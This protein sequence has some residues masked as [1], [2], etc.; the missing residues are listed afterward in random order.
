MPQPPSVIVVPPPS[1]YPAPP[2]TFVLPTP[3]WYPQEDAAARLA[4]IA[5]ADAPFVNGVLDGNWVA[6]L[7]SKRPGTI[8]DG[9]SYTSLDILNEHLEL[10]AEYNAKLLTKKGYWV[11]VAPIVF[12]D[13]ASAAN[14]CNSTGRATPYH[15]FATLLNIDA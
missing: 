11:T 1:A 6:Q 9:K 15:C 10:R 14:W 8:D 4:R 13:Q 2:P 5:A 12:P 3:T 7:S